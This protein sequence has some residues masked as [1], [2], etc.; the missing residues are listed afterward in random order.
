MNRAERRQHKYRLRRHDERIINSW[1]YE[2]EDLKRGSS[3]RPGYEYWSRRPGPIVPGKENKQI[4]HGI[5]RMRER[6]LLFAVGA[7]I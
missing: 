5:E 6:Q 2:K 7:G 4:T 3:K 1:G